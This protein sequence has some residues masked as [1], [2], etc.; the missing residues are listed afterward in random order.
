MYMAFFFLCTDACIIESVHW[1]VMKRH[2]EAWVL[3][4]IIRCEVELK[5]KEKWFYIRIYIVSR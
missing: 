4:Y 1:L 3:L 5:K 2:L